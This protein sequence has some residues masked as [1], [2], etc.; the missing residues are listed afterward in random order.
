VEG[1]RR[2]ICL[3]G[4]RLSGDTLLEKSSLKSSSAPL[5]GQSLPRIWAA[6]KVE[7]GAQNVEVVHVVAQ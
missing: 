7:V 2:H 6:A 3:C 1:S 5:Q 4:L